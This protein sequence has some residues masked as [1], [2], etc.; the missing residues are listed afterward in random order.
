VA[1]A[2]VGSETVGGVRWLLDFIGGIVKGQPPQHSPLN[3]YVHL[4]ALIQGNKVPMLT[5][6]YEDGQSEEM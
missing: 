6:G 3:G 5:C 1:I 4:P 2:L